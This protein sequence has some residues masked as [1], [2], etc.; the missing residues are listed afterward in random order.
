MG[1]A[2][3]VCGQ[4]IKGL[5]YLSIEI[6]FIYYMITKGINNL[7]GLVTLGTQEQGMYYNEA[8]QLYERIDGDNS[9]KLLLAGVVTL[10]VIAMFCIT[11]Y[12]SFKSGKEVLIAKEQGQKINSFKEDF[13]SLFDKNA[14]KLFL[15]IPI[16]GL[17]CFTVMPLIYMILIAFT[18]FDVNHQPPGKLFDWVGLRNFKI[19]IASSDVLTDTF[20]PILGWTVV[21]AFFATF[22]N[23]F[24][25]MLLAIMINIKSLKFKKLWRTVFVITISIPAFVSLMVIRAM[26]NPHGIINIGLI[27]MGFITESLPFL[28]NPTWARASVIITNMWIGIP[29]TML[30]TTGILSNIPSEIYE[31]AR[32]DGASPV[33]IFTKITFPYIFFITTPYLILNFVNNFNNFNPIYLMTEGGPPT[34]DYFKGA[35]K[36]DLLVTWLFKLTRDSFDYCYASAIG[37]I[38]FIITAS[39]SLM[40]YSRTK[41]YK[42]EEGMQI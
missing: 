14:H 38:V 31:S 2:Q 34:L 1:F 40:V 19:L 39:L 32:I 25:G 27:N 8:T 35:G 23:Y 13:L 41:A 3:L 15:L 21:W 4:I 33:K 28:T 11:W 18:N 6:G 9:M 12:I 20:W 29:Y 36:T 17:I 10:V 37:I 22:T 30:I 26:L 5:I 42:D 7:I 24:G 16:G